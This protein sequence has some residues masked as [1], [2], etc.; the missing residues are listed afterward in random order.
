M[1]KEWFQGPLIPKSVNIIFDDYKAEEQAFIELLLEWLPVEPTTPSA[2]CHFFE[3]ISE[4]VRAEPTKFID[5]NHLIPTMRAR[6]IEIAARLYSVAFGDAV[7][8]YLQQTRNAQIK[9]GT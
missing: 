9:E 4:E 5:P 6:K 2:Y 8:S 7:E 3:R 1:F